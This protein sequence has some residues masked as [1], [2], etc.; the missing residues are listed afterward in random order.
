MDLFKK[1]TKKEVLFTL[2]IIVSLSLPSVS[3]TEHT[4]YF[5]D[6][7]LSVSNTGTITID[8]LTNHPDISIGP[9]DT[10]TS[11]RGDLW[12]VNFTVEDPFSTFIYTLIL[13]KT[14]V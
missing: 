5:A 2:I 3:S 1:L 14:L 7:E 8:G 12:I 10:F 6:L 4:D 13:L 11:K 9:T